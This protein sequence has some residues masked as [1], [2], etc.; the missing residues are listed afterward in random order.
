[1]RKENLAI[2]TTSAPV[3][4]P[5]VETTPDSSIPS[6]SSSSSSSSSPSSPSIP[7]NSSRSS[8]SPVT[9]YALQICASRTLLDPSDPKLKG[10]TCEYRKVGDWYK[11]YAI[12]DTDRNKVVEKQKEIKKLFPDCWIT[13]FEK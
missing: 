3:A 11:Y 6:S 12:V 1:M 13:K 2:D 10:L 9:Y 8:N 5:S 4:A 7:F